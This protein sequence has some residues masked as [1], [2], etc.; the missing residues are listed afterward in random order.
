MIAVL[1]RRIG[2]LWFLPAACLIQAGGAEGPWRLGSAL[3]LPGWA[4]LSGEHRLRYESLGNQFRAGH[5]GSDQA[6]ALRTSV[7]GQIKT[8][9]VGLVTEIMDS[10][11]YLSDSGSPIDN[12]QVDAL[13]VLQAHVRWNAGPLFTGGHHRI[14]FGRETL[15]LGNR[16]LVAR[17]AYRNTLNAFTGVDWLWTGDSAGSIRSFAFLPVRRLPEDAPSLLDNRITADS[18]SFGQQFYGVYA[19][20]PRLAADAR[21]EAYWMGLFEDT[22]PSRRHRRLHTTGSRLFRDAQPGQWDF[23][24]E[25]TL[26]RGSSR[27]TTG[28]SPDLEH[29]AWLLQVGAGYTWKTFGTPRV[30]VRVDQASGD[31]NPNDGV[32][33]RFDTLFGARRFDFGPTGIYGAI[34]RSNLRS[35]E[36]RA[37]MRPIPSLETS[38]SHRWIWLESPFDAFTAAAVRDASGRSGSSVGQQ[39]EGRIRWDI[40][41]GNCRLDTGVATLFKGSFLENA[42]NANPNGDAVYGW[43]EWTFTF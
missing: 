17:N 20:S 36:V 27:A 3:D 6:L 31:R 12:T 41:P 25:A 2:F 16:R 23:E 9:P 35:P 26:Q 15:D 10:R 18:Q 21:V 22:D 33:Q 32:N 11:Q 43:V 4:D 28:I 40:V 42:P 5:P 39:L 13:E 8:Q 19:T 24:A 1:R 7:L 34:A 29:T 14:Q 30:G 38:L 37:S